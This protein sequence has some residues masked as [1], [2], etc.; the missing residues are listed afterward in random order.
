MLSFTS[1]YSL[2][3]SLS[4]SLSFFLSLPCLALSPTLIV[5]YKNPGINFQLII[6]CNK[7]FRFTSW[8]HL[9]VAHNK[10]T[11]LRF[12]IFILAND[13]ISIENFLSNFIGLKS[14]QWPRSAIE[15]GCLNWPSAKNKDIQGFLKNKVKPLQRKVSKMS[16]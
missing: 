3:L 2:S 6:D 5:W 15:F 7:L 9:E 4:L 16:H 11:N 10:F 1:S 14:N 12:F 8:F 13:K